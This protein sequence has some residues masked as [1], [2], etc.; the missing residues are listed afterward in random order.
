MTTAAYDFRSPPPA[1]LERQVSA[2]LAEV[3]RRVVKDW[4]GALPFPVTFE[5]QPPALVTGSTVAAA[6]VP[7]DFCFQLV[8]PAPQ[9]TLWVGLAA[10]LG[11]GLVSGLL[12]ESAPTPQTPR[13][14]T[15]L[16]MPVFD[17]LAGD[18]FAPLLAA[19]WPRPG[20][21]AFALGSRGTAREHWRPGDDMAVLARL[22]AT[23][24][25]GTFQIH[26]VLPRADWADRLVVTPAPARPP[27]TVADRDNMER[28]VKEMA[29][30]L[31]VEL[32]TADV[33]LTELARLRSGDVV[34]LNRKVSDPL[35]AS[36]AGM[37]KFRVWPGAV[38]SRYA[39]QV[40]TLD[41]RPAEAA[42]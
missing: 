42:P 2:W 31:T 18:L 28:V 34:V 13:G 17:F 24:P 39:V 1:D 21:P 14:L 15:P 10:P 40:H 33:T 3:C 27:V 22:D 7:D 36:V 32:G 41:A 5:P 20:G 38:G 35:E 26:L 23:A 19:A 37:Q 30:D 12:G 29:V 8:T 25:F 6:I 4:G 16:E 9:A 11:L